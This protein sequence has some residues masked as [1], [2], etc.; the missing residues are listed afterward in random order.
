MCEGL[1]TAYSQACP[2]SPELIHTP[3][4]VLRTVACPRPGGLP[5]TLQ[6]PPPGPTRRGKGRSVPVKMHW[7]AAVYMNPSPFEKVKLTDLIVVRCGELVC[8]HGSIS[9]GPDGQNGG[10]RSILV[11]ALSGDDGNSVIWGWECTHYVLV[12]P[13]TKFS[14]QFIRDDLVATPPSVS[15]HPW[16]CKFNAGTFLLPEQKT[17]FR[18]E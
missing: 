15:D 16:Y 2:G 10:E 8:G 6:C 3:V 7:L 1:G 14:T 11:K 9:G 12:W 4:G 18:A 17:W 13:A 5:D